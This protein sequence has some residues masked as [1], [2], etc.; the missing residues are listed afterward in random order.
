MSHIDMREVGIGRPD[1]EIHGMVKKPERAK[2]VVKL[3][4]K[5]TFSENDIKAILAR[6]VEVEFDIDKEIPLTDVKG[7]YTKATYGNQFDSSPGYCD[8][9][10]TVRG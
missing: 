8:F 5:F 1:Y 3:E 10:V 9:T 2:P 6:Y 7:D 4:R